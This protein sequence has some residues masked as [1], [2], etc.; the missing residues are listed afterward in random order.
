[1]PVKKMTVFLMC[2][3]AMLGCVTVINCL[4][5]ETSTPP[6]TSTA[7]PDHAR[8]G[9]TITVAWNLAPAHLDA[10]KSTASEYGAVGYNIFEGLFEPNAAQ[11]AT[12]HLAEGVKIENG[13]KTYLIQLRKG[14]KFHNGKEMDAEDVIASF[15]RWIENNGGGKMVAPYF[16]TITRGSNPYEVIIS[17]KQLYAPFLNILASNVGNQKM[18]VMPKE[19]VEA[20]GKN[21]IDNPVGTGPYKLAGFI[22]DQYAKLVRFDGYVPVKTPA[23]FMAGERKAYA[24]EII[25]KFVPEEAVRIAGVQSGE[26]D[27]AV[28]VTNDQYPILAG[29]RNA[30]PLIV[31]ETMEHFLIFNGA[32]PP[33]DNIKARQ[34]LNYC[35]NIDM[36]AMATSGDPKFWTVDPSYMI[37][38]SAWYTP[39][40][41]KGIYNTVDLEKAKQL[42]KESGYTGTPI[43]ILCSSADTVSVQAAQVVKAQAEAAGFRMDVQVYDRPTAVGIRSKKEGWHIFPCAFIASNPDPQVFGAWMGTNRWITNWDDADSRKMDDLFARMMIEIDPVKRLE[44]VREWNQEIYRTLPYIKLH[45]YSVLHANAKTLKGLEAHPRIMFWNTW[46]ENK[47]AN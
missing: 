11:I 4:S 30:E 40:V 33:F 25:Y 39:N 14:V 26:F 1:M 15:T 32:Q 42:L 7:K 21:P 44:T 6:V 23:S 43:V 22:P 41:G 8:Y 38:A 19:S 13:G 17:L 28:Q 46:K 47:S 36:I 20:A 45:N 16:E 24:D 34:A 12:P 5:K 9:G 29:D 37:R 31:P 35:L 3:I 18:F 2:F 10:N 27:F